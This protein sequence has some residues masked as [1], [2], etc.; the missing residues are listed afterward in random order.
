MK[1]HIQNSHFNHQTIRAHFNQD[2][3]I[4]EIMTVIKMLIPTMNYTIEGNEIYIK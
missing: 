4:V 2:D 1:V 3:S